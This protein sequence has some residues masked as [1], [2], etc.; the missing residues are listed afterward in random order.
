MRFDF[1]TGL[2]DYHS[3]DFQ[4]DI[5]QH[6]VISFHSQQS[7]LGLGPHHTR[8]RISPFQQ[9]TSFLTYL[10]I[11]KFHNNTKIHT[12]FPFKS[13]TRQCKWTLVPKCVVT[14][15]GLTGSSKNGNGS[16]VVESASSSISL[17]SGVS[18]NGD[19]NSCQK[20]FGYESNGS[21]SRGFIT[22]IDKKWKKERKSEQWNGE[23]KW[24]G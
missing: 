7:Y 21:P 10:S 3:D 6:D 15:T 22:A 23:K 17:L 9:L 13:L 11:Y 5:C 19:E 2:I 8:R 16:W 20:F 1:P 24:N 4:P 18:V 12:V 14:L